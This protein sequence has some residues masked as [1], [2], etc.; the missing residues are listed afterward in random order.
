MLPADYHTHN[1]LCQHAEGTLTEYAQNAILN[2]VAEIGFSDHSPMPQDGYDDWRMLLSQ[3]PEYLSMAEEAKAKFPDFP[4]RVGL[5]VDYLPEQEDWIRD[6]AQRYPWDYLIGSVHYLGSWD[7]DNPA[8]IQT[9]HQSDVNEVWKRYF[10]VL[11]RAAASGLFNIIGHAD[12]PKKFN[13]RPT[14]D[15]TTSY[16]AFLKAAAKTQTAIEIN[17]A[18]WDKD[19]H[20]AYPGMEILRLAHLEGVPLTFGSDSHAPVHVGKYFDKAVI[21][22]KQAGYT[23]SVRFCRRKATFHELPE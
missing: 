11:T 22:A 3:L 17:T 14:C 9:W 5:E 8:K 6:L 23:H 21:L 7:I 16:R 4:I 13:F 1:Y 15:C 18:G 12:L 19:C 2:G 10:E 20:E